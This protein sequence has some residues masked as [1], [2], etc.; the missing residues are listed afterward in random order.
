MNME[1]EIKECPEGSVNGTCKTE[2]CIFQEGKW[3][4]ENAP[5][6]LVTQSEKDKSKYLISCDDL[7]E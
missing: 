6:L 2:D 3:K 1:I 7:T 5:S 4:G